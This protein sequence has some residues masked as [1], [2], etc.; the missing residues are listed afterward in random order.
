MRLRKS[1][2]PVMRRKLIET[3]ALLD[4]RVNTA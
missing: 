3:R 4:R 1:V 2:A